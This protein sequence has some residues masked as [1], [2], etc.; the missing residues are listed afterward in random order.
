MRRQEERRRHFSRRVR[1]V[2]LPSS[3]LYQTILRKYNPS[4]RMILYGCATSSAEEACTSSTS[5]MFEL[6][7][8][9]VRAAAKPRPSGRSGQRES[10]AWGSLGCIPHPRKATSR[11]LDLPREFLSIFRA[12]SLGSSSRQANGNLDLRDG[13][14]GAFS[15]AVNGRTLV[16]RQGAL[17]AGQSYT[18]SLSATD[19]S[20]LT[21]YAGTGGPG[22]QAI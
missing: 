22:A 17:G 1:Y 10:K 5:S 11:R 6:E 8:G 21:G 14:G 16:A 19:T 9:Q 13:W 18:F 7:W 3:L 20:G 4:E 15:T 2:P 12:N